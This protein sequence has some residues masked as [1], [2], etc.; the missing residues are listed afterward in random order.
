M[1]AERPVIWM[2]SSRGDVRGFPL[3]VRRDI[4]YARYAAQR[5]EA[6]PASKPL[7]GFGGGAVLEII[8]RH[9]GDTWRAVYTVRYPEAIYV[10]HAFQRNRSEA[11][12]Q[13]KRTWNLFASG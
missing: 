6:D 7:Q 12:P 13:R 4:G 8:V 3:Q 10:L 1:T 11:L 9:R 5:G 2:G